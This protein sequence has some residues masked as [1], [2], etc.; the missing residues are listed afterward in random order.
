MRLFRC[1]LLLLILFTLHISLFAD[2]GPKPSMKFKLVYKTSKPV[3]VIEG[4]QLESKFQAFNV[5]DTLIRRGPQGFNLSQDKASSVSY[6]YDDYHKIAIKFD[7]RV[8]ES[9]VFQDESFN[10][11]YELTVYDDRME[12]KDVTSF[13]KDSTVMA[14]FIKALLL[15]LALELLVAFIYL[16]LAKKPLKILLVVIL[17]NLFTVPMLWFV[18]PLMLNIGSAI[19]AGELFAFITE[20]LFLLTLSRKWFKPGGAFLLSFMMN[21]LSLLIGGLALLLMIGF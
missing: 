2:A 11:S 15:T 16:K 7:D 8:R 21:L 10:S 6:G 18:F 4:W 13:M 14:T 17:G 3:K 5:F 9:N 20:A 19:L 12:V 1:L